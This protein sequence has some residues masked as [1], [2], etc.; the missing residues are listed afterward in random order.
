MKNRIKTIIASMLLYPVMAAS[1]QPEWGANKFIDAFSDKCA[2]SVTENG[3]IY[4][5]HQF[6]PSL[7]SELNGWRLYESTDGG[8]SF[9]LAAERSNDVNDL[10]LKDVD[11][12]ATGDQE[13]NIKVFI[14]ELWNTGSNGSW[15]GRIAIIRYMP[16]TY[17][18][19]YEKFHGTDP[20][21]SLSLASDS[22]APGSDASPFAVAVAWTGYNSALQADEL[23]L[24]YSLSG[25]D[26]YTYRN[27]YQ[28]PGINRV[29]LSLGGNSQLDI[30]YYAIAFETNYDAG[31]GLGNAGLFLGRISSFAN[32]WAEPVLVNTKFSS[33]IGKVSRPSV[34]IMQD[35]N[36]YVPG[37]N[38]VPLLIAMEDHSNASNSDLI[39]M[40]FN[41]TYQFTGFNP[42]VPDM[43]MIEITYPFG[44]NSSHHEKNPHMVYDRDYNHFLMTYSTENTE[45][46]IYTGIQAGN[47]FTDDWWVMGNYR[48]NTGDLPDDPMP[49][50]DIDLSQGK[51]V[52]GWKDN[53][54]SLLFPA[55]SYIDAEWWVLGL[56]E[57]KALE[58]VAIYPNPA[59][60]RITIQ[61]QRPSEF[62]Y[63]IYDSRGRV[64]MSGEGNQ[65]QTL[66]NISPSIPRGIYLVKI[67]TPE[68]EIVKKML[69]Q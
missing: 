32:A 34:C 46:L 15:N 47:L 63:G 21:Y 17:Q 28:F 6:R 18:L 9:S 2:V 23:H 53:Y 58:S 3:W 1:A 54:Q 68:G 52:F 12:V 51:A 50:V 43:S 27:M 14:G 37:S 19:V 39:V 30:G 41:G 45:E 67:K 65:A 31:S 57:G 8:W 66:L 56:P 5:L 35:Q 61:L 49:H 10:D 7:T 13:S 29:S 22:R 16:G 20:A 26:I 44:T 25:G 11:L 36:D 69:L 64:V 55:R 62:I 59:L 48:S 38:F 40:R 60:D 33:L 42:E 24:A 4:V